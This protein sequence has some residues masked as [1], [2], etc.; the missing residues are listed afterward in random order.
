M[1]NF[2]I[3]LFFSSFLTFSP[4]ISSVSVFFLSL[5]LSYILFLH[6]VISFCFNKFHNIKNTMTC[7]MPSCLRFCVFTT[8]FP[9]AKKLSAN[10]HRKCV[11]ILSQSIAC[12]IPRKSS[13]RNKHDNYSCIEIMF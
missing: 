1:N 9:D 5:F 12:R 4:Y 11:Y 7:I 6:F 13:R 8:G 2:T 3:L 10:H